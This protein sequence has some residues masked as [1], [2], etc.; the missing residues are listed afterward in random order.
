MINNLENQI[1]KNLDRL[2]EREVYWSKK[3]KEVMDRKD[4][5]KYTNTSRLYTEQN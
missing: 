1:T 5:I 4:I 3:V 2:K